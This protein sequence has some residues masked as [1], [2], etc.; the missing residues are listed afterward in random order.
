VGGGT[1]GWRKS[2]DEQVRQRSLLD[3]SLS[4]LSRAQLHGHVQASSQYGHWRNSVGLAHRQVCTTCLV[5]IDHPL[6]VSRRRVASRSRETR[7]RELPVNPL[8]CAS[9]RKG[10]WRRSAMRVPRQSSRIKC[11]F[12]SVTPDAVIIPHLQEIVRARRTHPRTAKPRSK[13]P[14]SSRRCRLSS[15]RLSRQRDCGDHERCLAIRPRTPCG[16]QVPRLEA[17]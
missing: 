15:L 4:W 12:G 11:R 5:S 9:N 10:T 14:G 6:S 3:R 17:R 1:P 2:H 13:Q 7:A 8:R 16:R